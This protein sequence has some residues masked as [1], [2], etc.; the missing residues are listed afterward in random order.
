MAHE[1]TR[2]LLHSCAPTNH[3]QPSGYYSNVSPKP[4]SRMPHK[5]VPTG[6]NKL[7]PQ[8]IHTA[9]LVPTIIAL[10]GVES[11]YRSAVKVST[12]KLNP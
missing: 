7:Q 10:S 2:K 6:Y 11:I 8:P 4:L 9:T 12:C 1:A 5:R 3:Q